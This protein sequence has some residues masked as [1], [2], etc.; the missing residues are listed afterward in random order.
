MNK[1]VYGLVCAGGGAHGAYQVGVLKYI[2]QHFSEDNRSPF[3]IFTG[4]SCG[5]LNTT[6]F[7][8]ESHNSRAMSLK[9]EELWMSFHVPA[10]H[11]NIF[12]NVLLGLLK[13]MR[14]HHASRWAGLLDPS[15][16][17]KIIEIGY[18]RSHL[19]EAFR[20]GST[21][22]VGVAAT[23]IVSGRTCW[24]LEGPR[25]Q[26]WNL[27]HSLSLPTHIESHHIAA[28]CSV[29]VFLPPVKIGAH[30]FLDGTVNLTKPLSAA[31]TMGASKVLSI[32]TDRPLPQGLPDQRHDLKPRLSTVIRFLLNQLG[33]DSAADEVAEIQ[34][35]NRFY[36]G[37]SR[38]SRA[39]NND[40]SNL[41]LF[42]HE[43]KPSHY[44]QIEIFRLMPS[45]RIRSISG[46]E[47]GG[48]SVRNRTR[49]MF[50]TSFIRELIDFGYQDAKQQHDVLKSFFQSSA[51]KR[52]WFP[53]S[54]KRA[55]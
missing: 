32:G 20:K 35:L 47:E 14:S 27:F 30:Y 45:K 48:L 21:L 24:F 39:M 43:S 8:A 15:P 34:T 18:Q 50:H 36:E 22:G 31:I 44:Q 25:S 49:F 54:E 53:F 52:N 6:F 5:A 42:H 40:E 12:K 9:L 28:S 29:P 2:H 11:G 16:M 41:P 1:P 51:T 10:Y 4:A 7:A 3:Q 13:Q 55:A 19:E 23:E 17:Q 46:I 37:L 26:E 33:R 38:K